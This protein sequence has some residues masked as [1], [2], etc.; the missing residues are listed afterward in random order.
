MLYQRHSRK[1][2]AMTRRAFSPGGAHII[3]SLYMEPFPIKTQTEYGMTCKVL[4]AGVVLK[5]HSSASVLH[6][7]Q[8][9]SEL[10][11]TSIKLPLSDPRFGMICI[12][13]G[14]QEFYMPINHPSVGGSPILSHTRTVLTCLVLQCG[15]LCAFLRLLYGWRKSLLLNWHAE[16][17]KLPV[18]FNQSSLT[19]LPHFCFLS[20]FFKKIWLRIECSNACKTSPKDPPHPNK[21]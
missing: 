6:A 15:A 20:L 13:L 3:Y 21:L 14:L 17:C 18:H 4:D 12:D 16:A 10:L 9:L 5:Y 7:L 8:Q 1:L 19:I 11:C 2:K